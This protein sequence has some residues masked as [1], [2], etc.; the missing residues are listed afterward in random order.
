MKKFN[1]IFLI[2]FKYVYKDHI[3]I[4]VYYFT[5]VCQIKICTNILLQNQSRDNS[6]IKYYIF[7]C[8]YICNYC[9]HIECNNLISSTVKIFIYHA[10]I[11][12]TD[13]EGN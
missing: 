13:E 6:I 5:L 9:I 1:N 11:T 7:I 8:I 4:H 3:V 2:Y 12:G 10:F